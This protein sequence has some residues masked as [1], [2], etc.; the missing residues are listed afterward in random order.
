[1]T[2]LFLVETMTFVTQLKLIIKT[3]R[4]GVKNWKHILIYH[5]SLL[6]VTHFRR[7]LKLELTCFINDME[8]V[9]MV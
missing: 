5:V 4:N 2:N 8:F 3:S 1:M 6:R 9:V 7:I